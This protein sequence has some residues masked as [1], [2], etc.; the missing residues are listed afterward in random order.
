MKLTCKNALGLFTFLFV[1]GVVILAAA[2]F[3]RDMPIHSTMQIAG[4]VSI[5]L[6]LI[7]Y[8]T[9]WRCPACRELL[10]RGTTVPPSCKNCGQRLRDDENKGG[11]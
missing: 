6:G 9:F 3:M 10:P 7:V 11:D 8:T 1:A 4:A 2:N 5:A